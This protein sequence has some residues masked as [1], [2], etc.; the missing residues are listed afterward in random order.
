MAEGKLQKYVLTINGKL[1][2]EWLR[3]ML[4][5]NVGLVTENSIALRITHGIH[6]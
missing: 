6:L 4:P 2:K 3:R 1:R 5:S